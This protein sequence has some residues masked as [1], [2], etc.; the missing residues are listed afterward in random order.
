[1]L[2][3]V[4]REDA[5]LIIQEFMKGTDMDA[6]VYVDTISKQ[7]VAIF[8]KKKISTTIGGAN[9]TISFKDPALFKFV[10]EVIQV[11]EFN[12]PLDMD[13]F[14]RMDSIIFL[15]SIPDLAV[16]TCMLMGQ[17]LTSRK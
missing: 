15:R 3:D 1:M 6:D 2:R 12:G 11:L 10:K 5:S 9:K 7:P 4:I 17:G 14:I 8:S 13:L 16:R